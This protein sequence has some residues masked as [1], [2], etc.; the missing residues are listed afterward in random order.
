MI[1]AFFVYF[2]RIFLAIALT[3]GLLIG[4]ISFITLM[5]PPADVALFLLR[6]VI[7]MA[8]IITAIGHL[9]RHW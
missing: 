8:L 9:L 1:K 4:T 2:T 6:I 3:F 5:V 7:V